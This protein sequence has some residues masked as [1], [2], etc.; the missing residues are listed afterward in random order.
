MDYSLPWLHRASICL[1]VWVLHVKHTS[2]QHLHHSWSCQV[3]ATVE[4]F[5][6]I[7]TLWTVIYSCLAHCIC[8]LICS[9]TLVKHNNKLAN[10]SDSD[11]EMSSQTNLRLFAGQPT[12]VFWINFNGIVAKFCL[13]NSLEV[14]TALRQVTVTLYPPET[15]RPFNTAANLE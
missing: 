11:K 5:V 6:Q 14:V 1:H 4:I 2:R 12:H 15:R 3:L 9:L 7:L 13:R 8:S 10:D